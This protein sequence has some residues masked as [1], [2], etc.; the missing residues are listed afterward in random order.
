MVEA[1][2]SGAAVFTEVRDRQVKAFSFTDSNGGVVSGSIP[3]NSRPVLGAGGFQVHARQPFHMASDRFSIG[4]EATYGLSWGSH[5]SSMSWS[6]AADASINVLN[7]G[8]RI[9]GKLGYGGY[10][11][12]SNSTFP[13]TRHGVKAGLEGAIR[14]LSS[15]DFVSQA[16]VI[17]TPEGP[18]TLIT[19]GAQ[20]LFNKRPEPPVELDGSLGRQSMYIAEQKLN[21]MERAYYIPRAMTE[22]SMGPDGTVIDRLIALSGI[23]T[24]L[25]RND[26]FA[27]L[28]AVD[29]ELAMVVVAI[30]NASNNGVKASLLSPLRK[31]A[32]EFKAK[33][34]AEIV[35]VTRG[36]VDETERLYC[37]KASDLAGTD[38]SDAASKALDACVE[39]LGTLQTL[40]S[41]L[42]SILPPA[43]REDAT[44]LQLRLDCLLKANRCTSD[45]DPTRTVPAM[46]R[47]IKPNGNRTEEDPKLRKSK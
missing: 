44:T 10:K 21:D 15:L 7:G 30:D 12:E 39:N 5:Y 32:R 25:V 43:V 14:L 13:E 28:P 37:R 46:Q 36:L 42:E 18:Q 31:L 4:P 11:V 47:R 9:S 33:R 17:L 1:G 45:F 41:M 38:K 3:L 22:L 29:D 34:Y 23:S 20:W 26:I 35:H 40:L 19:F 27:T 16:G 6:M 24:A 2:V 8:A